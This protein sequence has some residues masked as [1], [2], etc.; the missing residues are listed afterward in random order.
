MIIIR[1]S[2]GLGNQMFQYALYLR[3]RALGREVCF[4]DW[5]QYDAET[6]AGS[7][8]KRRK[9]AL[10]VFG[11]SYP[12][13]DPEELERMTDSS[14]KPADRLRRKIHGRKSLEKRDSDFIFDSSFLEQTEGYYC[15][16]FQ[17]PRY[18]EG[19]E[20]EVRSAFTFPED[21][22]MED[23][24]QTENR[25]QSGTGADAAREKT[26]RQE[27]ARMAERIRAAGGHS[28][29]VHLRFG[30][31]LDKSDIYG[32]ICTD[33]YYDEG[34]RKVLQEDPEAVFFIFSNDPA[35][36][37]DWIRIRAEQSGNL[38]RHRFVLVTG[39]D[40]DHGYYDLY[41]MTLCRFHIIANSSFS[42][43][44]SWLS[45]Q[46]GKMIIA[47]SIWNNEKDGSEL[48]RTDIY[49]KEMIRISPDGHTP[50]ER[51]LVSVIVTAFNV[52]PYIRKAMDSVCSQTW[53]N[54]EIIA[55]DDGSSDGTGEIL[56]QY[57]EEDARVRVIHTGNRG[58]S[59]ARNAGLA[60]A[61][62]EYVG[63]VDGDDT[64]H[65][66]MIEAMVRGILSSGAD[67]ATVNYAGV[68]Q[69]TA[70]G[71][72]CDDTE[73]LQVPAGAVKP[74]EHSEIPENAGRKDENAG[75]VRIIGR[76][77]LLTRERAVRAFIHAGIEGTDGEIVL[78]SA[79]WS[80]LF[81]RR[82][83]KD[84]LFPEGTSAE[85]IPFT[86]KA[87]CQS[88]KVL[89]LPDILYDYMRNRSDS[90]M[91]SDRADRAIT[92][93]IPAWHTHFDLLRSEGLDALAEESEYYYYRRLLSYEEEYRACQDTQSEA[94]ELEKRIL[95]K[96]DRILEL[97][98]GTPYGRRGDRERLKLYVHS[99][100]LYRGLAGLYEKTVVAWK[101]RKGQP[102]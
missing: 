7:T 13:A 6:F 50:D 97:T 58:V 88:R 23:V 34:I 40:E 68:E 93:E 53:E 5:T 55:V 4:D 20:D 95:A 49:T 102:S 48:A 59:A 75:T 90:I 79:V 47:P 82:V 61:S 2:G 64:A 98:A 83:L 26:M 78:H 44:G 52:A 81:G 54:L 14:M 35:L 100:R 15:G 21:L 33:A 30:D 27:T 89:Y 76:S 99:P 24:E 84:N 19:I 57:A 38:G 71:E 12:A 36:A 42:W 70:A 29:S 9:K 74:E 62:G 94:E 37:G 92:Q 67:M 69:N 60:A 1:M 45:T 73:N 18:F 85:D 96:K 56:N 72:E 87:L 101:N 17:S 77:V 10:G 63:F 46:P 66:Q 32:G 8:Q 41:L 16:G 43:W 11:I 80:K 22:S 25:D 31:Y 51:P 28:A 39:R 86:T 91:N 3:L 65:P